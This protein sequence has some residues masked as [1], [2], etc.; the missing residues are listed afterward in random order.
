M[1]SFIQKQVEN[2]KYNGCCAGIKAWSANK[3]KWRI[4]LGAPGAPHQEI[5]EIIQVKWCNLDSFNL[6]KWI[7]F[8]GI[9]Q[10]RNRGG[11]VYKENQEFWLFGWS[12]LS[13]SS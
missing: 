3:P 2:N 6:V 12:R 4:G 11:T 8:G 10:N 13:I 9:E 7:G 5:F 1:T